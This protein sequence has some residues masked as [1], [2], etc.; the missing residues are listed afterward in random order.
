MGERQPSDD[1]TTIYIRISS[2]G[3][4]VSSRVIAQLVGA[5]SPDGQEYRRCRF[6]DVSLTVWAKKKSV[7]TQPAH[8]DTPGLHAK[9]GTC[10]GTNYT[11]NELNCV[12]TQLLIYMEQLISR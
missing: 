11:P 10:V 9:F 6:S 7:G 8:A 3:A 12:I 2:V 4:P 5:C 1:C